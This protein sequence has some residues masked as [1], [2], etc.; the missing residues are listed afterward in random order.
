MANAKTYQ[1]EKCNKIYSHRQH[2]FRHKQQCIKSVL[3]NCRSCS[4]SFARTDTLKKHSLICEKAKSS[5]IENKVC[6]VCQKKFVKIWHLRRHA[7]THSKNS[8]LYQCNICDKTYTREMFYKAHLQECDK[9]PRRSVS[10]KNTS[11]DDLVAINESTNYEDFVLDDDNDISDDGQ[12][13]ALFG[14]TNT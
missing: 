2:L 12:V 14:F 3:H 5:A 13:T 6:N 1:C 11:K 10:S 8:I 4:K 9:R 7:K